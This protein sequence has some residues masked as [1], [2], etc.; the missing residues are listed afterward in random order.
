VLGFLS[1]SSAYAGVVT[2]PLLIEI[3]GT[4]STSPGAVAIATAAYGLPGILI[5]LVVGPYSDRTGRKVL[6]IAGAALL[7]AGTLAAALAPTLGLLTVGRIFAGIGS[8]L[9]YPN[10]SAAVGGAVLPAERGRALSAVI[11]VNTVATI[12]GVPL[13]GILAEAT[14]WRVAVG[15]VAVLPLAAAVVLARALAEQQPGRS[16]GA[17]S[18]YGQVAASRSAVFAL[19]ASLLGSMFWFAWATFFVVFFQRTYGLALGAA[20]T[21][22]VTLG[23]GILIGS[24]LGGRVG[25]RIGHRAVAGTVIIASGVLMA[26]LTTGA[27]PLAAAAVLNLAVS[28]LIGARFAANQAL[29]SEQVPDARG[30]VFA[31]SSSLAS[32]AQVSA[33]AVAGV[34]IDGAGFGAIGVVCLT[35]GVVVSVITFTLVSERPRAASSN[36]ALAT[37][38]GS[39][40]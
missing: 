22:G 17:L 33:A 30:T 26:I 29:L 9:V 3:A 25:D 39:D 35:L 7:S 34:L 28:A 12:V 36:S 14:T 10:V 11:G 21:M 19:T 40:A 16:A 8:S 23:V 32:I 2:I 24:Q 37:V 13:A 1:F 20:S 5:P 31:L 18:T 15:F 27:L 4:F 6:L 38:V